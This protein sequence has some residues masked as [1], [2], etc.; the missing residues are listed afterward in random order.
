MGRQPKERGGE[1]RQ[2]K[3]R[4]GAR[5]EEEIERDKRKQSI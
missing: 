2:A 4:E 3:D 1:N 5:G